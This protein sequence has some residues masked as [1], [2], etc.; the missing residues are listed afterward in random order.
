MVFRFRRESKK[1][2]NMQIYKKAYDKL[3]LITFTYRQKTQ[4]ERIK[5]VSTV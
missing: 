4:S 1:I 5:L 3:F 2:Y